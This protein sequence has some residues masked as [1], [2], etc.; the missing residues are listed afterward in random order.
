MAH[1]LQHATPPRAEP[2][3]GANADLRTSGYAVAVVVNAI[4]LY[5]AHH[6]LAWGVPFLTP[7]FAEVLWAIDLSLGA[8]IVANAAFIAYDARWFRHLTGAALDAL[9]LLSTYTL[10]SVFPFHFEAPW[11]YETAALVLLIV[12]LVTAIALVVHVV[13]AIA[14][15]V[16]YAFAA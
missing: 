6:L 3:Q 2:W 11:W 7:A 1:Q 16:Q 10:Y 13:Q 15:G 4:L 5:V 9:S 14:D 12:M 8:A